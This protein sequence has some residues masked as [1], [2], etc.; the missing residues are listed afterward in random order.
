MSI[1]SHQ[2]EFSFMTGSFTIG[3][4]NTGN[5]VDVSNPTKQATV[6]AYVSNVLTFFNGS[7]SLTSTL[8]SFMTHDGY[9]YKMTIKN[10]AFV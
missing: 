1:P 2:G 8:S 5:T 3:E 4:Y 9:T 7:L 10:P 6:E